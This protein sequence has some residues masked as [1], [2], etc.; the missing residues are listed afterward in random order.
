MISSYIVALMQQVIE[1]SPA[2]WVLKF[3]RRRHRETT[4]QSMAS[5]PQIQSP[6]SIP[7]P[8]GRKPW[9]TVLLREWAALK[10]PGVRL[11]EQVKVGP[12]AV[13]L[14]DVHISPALEAAISVEN[15]RADGVIQLPNE[16]LFI[17][18][19]MDPTPSASSQVRFYIREAMRTPALQP[20]MSIPFV[21]VLL[22]AENDADVT[23]FC[24]QDGC[25]VELYTPSW[26]AD[27]ITQV[28]IRNRERPIPS[29]TVAPEGD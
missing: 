8:K 13:K 15:W 20:L 2:W 18:S 29:A 24:R 9:S 26:I 22:F 21:P 23:A 5:T 25:R 3:P 10:Y 17:E 28:Q 7:G 11:W 19:K 14:V 1:S 12:T 6:V 4:A 27:Y 16:I